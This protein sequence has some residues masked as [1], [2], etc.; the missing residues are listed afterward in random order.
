MNLLLTNDDGIDGAGLQ[1]LATLLRAQKRN[2]VYVL[3]P[4]TNRSGASHSISF[5][6]NPIRLTPHGAD[7]WSCSGT[8]VDCVIMALLGAL[9]V[10]IDLV[11]SGI[12]VGANM[13]TDLLY[14]GTAA[15]ARQATLFHVPSVAFSLDGNSPFYWD[16]AAAFAVQHLD[17]FA[18]LWKD[19]VFINVNIPNSPAPDG[20]AMTF[21]SLRDYHDSISL[22]DTPDGKRYC[23]AIAGD[24]TAAIDAGS[25][26]DAVLRNLVSVSPV[27]VHPVIRADPGKAAPAYASVAL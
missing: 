2:N 25:D 1:K 5:L 16:E 27:Y 23:F 18:A 22:Y 26:H 9:R 11:V 10:S 7:T 6:S 14:S 19:D 12:N 21:P 24:I 20:T 4:D 15:A 13:G 8:P 3:A 17:E